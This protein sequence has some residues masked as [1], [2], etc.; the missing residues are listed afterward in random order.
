MMKKRTLLMS[1]LAVALAAGMTIAPAMAYFTAHTEAVG[2]VAI[3]LG[4]KTH[5]EEN[6][7]GWNKTVIISNEGP[8]SV[9]VRA[10][11]IAG[12][13]LSLDYSGSWTLGTGGWYYYDGIV[14]KDGET[15]PLKIS[16]GN[17]PEEADEA[18][19]TVIYEC[20]RVFYDE[21]GN[22]IA[23]DAES[24]DWTVKAKTE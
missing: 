7:K 14:D 13:D 12:G 16:I 21:E 1:A 23:L 24:A 17:V 11:A 10:K 3:A 20:T 5:I 6:V 18:N 9:Y 4:D 2:S 22:P 19:V 15:D 8:E